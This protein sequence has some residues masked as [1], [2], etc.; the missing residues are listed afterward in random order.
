MYQNVKQEPTLMKMK[1]HSKERML[2]R[3]YN[4]E[5]GWQVHNF[6]KFFM[7]T[8]SISEACFSHAMKMKYECRMVDLV[9]KKIV[10]SIP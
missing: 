9:A 1:E 7:A 3:T 6:F 10:E 4:L 8:L 5:S 2:V